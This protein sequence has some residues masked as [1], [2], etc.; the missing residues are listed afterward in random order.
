MVGKCRYWAAPEVYRKIGRRLT[1]AD[2]F[3]KWKRRRAEPDLYP[4]TG[5][6]PP[7]WKR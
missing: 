3:R 5:Y 7:V 1:L 4:V 2:R 6:F